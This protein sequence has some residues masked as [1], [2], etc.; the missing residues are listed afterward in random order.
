ME[1]LSDVE[2][3]QRLALA[4]VVGAVLGV[5]RERLDRPAGLRTYMLVVEGAC[6]FMICAILLAQQI[7]QAGGVSDPGRI[8]ALVVLRRVE[9]RLL[10]S[11]SDRRREASE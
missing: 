10:G 5:E 1:V 3:V 7:A 9:L 11:K 2:A 6:L 8:A 4:M